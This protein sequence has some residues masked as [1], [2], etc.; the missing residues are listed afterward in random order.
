MKGRL[1][2]DPSSKISATDDGAANE[3][4]PAP[5]TDGREDECPPIFYSS[6]LMRHLTWIWRLRLAHPWDDILQFVDDI[7]SAFH[8]VLYHPD[9]GILFASVFM[10]FLIIPIGTIFG[11]RNSP[12]FFCLLSEL[13]AHVASNT[14]YHDLSRPS[15][16][17]LPVVKPT[18]GGCATQ[19]EPGRLLAEKIDGGA[20]RFSWKEAAGDACHAAWRLHGGASPAGWD[21][22]APNIV[23]ETI[24]TSYAGAPSFEFFL[25]TAVG[26]DGAPGPSGH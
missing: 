10:E 1:C 9:A 5:G 15:Y 22:F 16:V 19:T 21:Q 4:I 25:V 8:R 26:T 13:R 7:H 3:S 12:S 6:A 2:V 18:A 20:V 23:A 24:A 14:I 17:L 11:A